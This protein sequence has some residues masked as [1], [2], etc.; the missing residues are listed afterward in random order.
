MHLAR[1]AMQQLRRAGH[2]SAVRNGDRLM[3][4]ADAEHRPVTGS[5]THELETAARAFGCAGTRTQQDAVHA[6]TFDVSGLDV[7][8]ASYDAL[9]AQLPEVGD[10]VV[11]EAVVVVDDED[12]RHLPLPFA[13]LAVFASS[14][15]RSCRRNTLPT[16]DC[17]SD[18]RN[19]ICFGSLYAVNSRAQCSTKSSAVSSEP[20]LST[21]NAFTVSPR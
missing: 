8:V 19:S 6:K 18:S 15:S 14:S 21:T 1:L 11:D 20:S 5:G 7:V 9:G 4:E 13:A 3:T 10:E 12:A 2:L 17:G 16:S